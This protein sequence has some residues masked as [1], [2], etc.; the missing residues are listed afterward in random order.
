MSSPKWVER[1][2]DSQVIHL[3]VFCP[4]EATTSTSGHLPVLLEVGRQVIHARKRTGMHRFQEKRVPDLECEVIIRSLW[5]KKVEDGSPMY[6][7]LEKIKSYRMGLVQWSRYRFG[8]IQN[9]IRARLD[10]L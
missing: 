6:C 4:P 7:L 8:G 5:S 1:F 2:H 10:T 3:T 9:R